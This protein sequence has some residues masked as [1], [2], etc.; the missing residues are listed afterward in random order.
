MDECTT[1]DHN[2]SERENN[3]CVNTDGSYMCECLTGFNRTRESEGVHTC[4]GK[5]NIVCPD[6]L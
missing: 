5:V 6:Y 1:D 2:C 3:Y 4:L